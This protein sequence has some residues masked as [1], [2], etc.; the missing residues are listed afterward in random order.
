MRHPADIHW[1]EQMQARARDI[2]VIA[3]T[4]YREMLMYGVPRE[5]AWASAKALE[6]TLWQDRI[7]DP[8]QAWA[9]HAELLHEL[10]ASY[11]DSAPF[12]P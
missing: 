12:A 11:D 1:S 8:D 6:T 5:E 10:R 2:A 3:A 7:F 4:Y 9:L